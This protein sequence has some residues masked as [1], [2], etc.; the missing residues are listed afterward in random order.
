MAMKTPCHRS[1]MKQ[2]AG[3]DAE[4]PLQP[5][6]PQASDQ[7][8]VANDGGPTRR[9]VIRNSEIGGLCFFFYVECFFP[10]CTE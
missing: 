9:F 7:K 2:F 3:R 4:R 8:E 10:S 6:L 5:V 1:L